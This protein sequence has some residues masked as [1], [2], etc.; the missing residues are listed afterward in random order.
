MKKQ[1]GTRWLSHT[2][3]VYDD[4]YMTQEYVCPVNSAGYRYVGPRMVAAMIMKA[5]GPKKPFPKA[6]ILHKD[7]VKTND[8]LSNLQW[9][10]PLWKTRKPKRIAVY[11]HG[12]LEDEIPSIKRLSKILQ[13]TPPTAKRIISEGREVDG[14]TYQYKTTETS[15]FA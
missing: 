1:I 5:F 6:R 2:G 3:K 11:H 14:R 8:H 4:R 9:G 15:L 12:I 10:K 13:V 7:G